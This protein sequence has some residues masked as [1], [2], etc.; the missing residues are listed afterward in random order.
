MKNMPYKTPIYKRHKG[1]RSTNKYRSVF[2]KPVAPEGYVFSHYDS[3]KKELVY[4]KK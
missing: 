1:F 3:D 2:R 4:K